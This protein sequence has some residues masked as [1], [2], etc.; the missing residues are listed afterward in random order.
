M[1]VVVVVVV[2]WSHTD[3]DV[4]GGYCVVLQLVR[5]RSYF[6]VFMLLSRESEGTSCLCYYVDDC[7]STPFTATPRIKCIV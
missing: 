4:G 5:V 6:F 3:G 7:W 1:V 2:S